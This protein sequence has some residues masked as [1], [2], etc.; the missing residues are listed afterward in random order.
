LSYNDSPPQVRRPRFRIL[1]DG[2]PLDGAFDIRVI[3]TDH[4]SPSRF[5]LRIVRG[6]STNGC[7]DCL[8]IQDDALLEVQ[9]SLDEDAGFASLVSGHGDTLRY[10]HP[11]RTIIIEGRDLAALLQDAPLS[12]TFSNMTS[13]E[14]AVTLAS[15]RG[16]VPRVTPTA[17]F[18]GRY[19]HSDTSQLAYNQFNRAST[20][21]DLLALLARC[22]SFDVFVQGTY[23]HFQPGNLIPST[24][25]VLSPDAL[26]DLRLRRRLRMSGDISV[27]VKSWNSKQNAAI[28]QTAISRR[29]DLD[30]MSN[31]IWSTATMQYSLVQPN[32][33]ESEAARMAL[34]R[35]SELTRHEVGVEILMPGEL[36]LGPRSLLVLQGTDSIFD[37]MYQVDTIERTLSGTAGFIQRVFGHSISTRH[38]FLLP[39]ITDP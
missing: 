29:T 23:L 28:V 6:S 12:D 7:I 31:V 9:I 24:S 38:S 8:S 11:T 19:Y 33:S 10:D 16:L 3:S 27:S 37:Q 18:A 26:I 34:S 14:I 17:T 13:S 32:L 1:A 36:T 22:E 5:Q 30:N 39:A 20:E 2:T 4:F 21:W 25:L 15:R 35:A